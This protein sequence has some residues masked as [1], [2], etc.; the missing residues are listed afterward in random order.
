[1]QNKK[2]NRVDNDPNFVRAYRVIETDKKT[3]YIPTSIPVG[4][5][6][7]R[8]LLA[9]TGIVL[10]SEMEGSYENVKVSKEE[11]REFLK[12]ATD[13]NFLAGLKGLEKEQYKKDLIDERIY[14]LQNTKTVDP[15]PEPEK[16]KKEPK[17]KVKVEETEKEGE[18]K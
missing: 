16:P 5:S 15:E 14:E 2:A 7:D 3:E 12:G 6:H 1:M 11:Y 17:A 18:N 9:V 8:N 10:A 4:L 13:A